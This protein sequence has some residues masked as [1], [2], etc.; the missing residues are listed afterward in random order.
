MWY[1]ISDFCVVSVLTKN[2]EWKEFS[3]KKEGDAI[4]FAK[5]YDKT[6][7]HNGITVKNKIHSIIWNT[8]KNY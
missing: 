5:G 8:P 4:E 1:E 6:F 2:G 7:Y 3:Y